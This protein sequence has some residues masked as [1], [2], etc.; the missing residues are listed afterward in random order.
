MKKKRTLLVFEYPSGI[1]G[2]GR[3][4]GKMV[5]SVLTPKQYERRYYRSKEHFRTEHAIEVSVL[6]RPY[7][8]YVKKKWIR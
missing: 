2:K 1:V 3:F 5:E 7:Y 6:Q 4:I 8:D